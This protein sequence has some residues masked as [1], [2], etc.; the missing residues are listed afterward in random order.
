MLKTQRSVY[1]TVVVLVAVISMMFGLSLA[2][3]MMQRSKQVP[4]H[5]TV[6]KEPRAISDFAL[7][8]IDG[9][10]Y[11]NDSLQQHWTIMFFGF[12]HCQSICP[13]TMAELGHMY[14]LLE[15][16]NAKVL[17]RVVMVTLDPSRDQLERLTQYVKAFDPHFFAARGK[18]DII[19]RM[20][21]E[22]GV[23][24]TSVNRQNLKQVIQNDIEHTGAVILFNPDGH[25]VAFFTGPHQAAFIAEDFLRL[26]Q[27]KLDS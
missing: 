14:R 6:L 20:T 13:T 27:G 25:V 8:G 15:Q 23:A 3:H 2:A 24:Y 7:M 22:L 16:K 5:G 1:K 26:T 18:D 11:T 10:P 9:Q 4:F 19:Q 17:P 21:R 12:T